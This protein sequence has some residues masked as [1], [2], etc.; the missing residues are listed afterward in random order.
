MQTTIKLTYEEQQALPVI[1]KL[2]KRKPE[3][4]ALLMQGM[5]R[6]VSVNVLLKARDELSDLQ[7][8]AVAFRQAS[9]TLVQIDKE[10]QDADVQV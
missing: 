5:A 2:L 6:E 1:R 4:A 3:A 7:K 8:I 9:Q 10:K